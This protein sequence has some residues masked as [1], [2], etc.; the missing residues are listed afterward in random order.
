MKNKYLIF[1]LVLA[2]IAII[3]SCKEDF[4][5]VKPAGAL[6]QNILADDAGIEAMIIGAYAVLDGQGGPGGWGSATTNWVYG[7][8]RGMESNKGTDAGDQPDI[9]PIQRFNETATNG[10]LN[11]KWR[12]VYDAI[13]RCNSTIIITNLALT[14]GAITQEQADQ[15]IQQARALRGWYHFDAWRMWGGKVPYV[16]ETTDAYTVSN[17]GDVRPQI[18][19]DLSEG[20]KL[21]VNMGAIGKFNKT[22]C[23][24][25]L[26][27]AQMDMNKDYTTALALLNDAR[28]NGKKPN[29]ADIGLAATY[30]EI[31][32]IVNRNGIEA[33]YTVQ[34]SVND[35][36]GG[37]NGGNGEVLNFPYKGGGS[38]G[39]CCGFF[40]P[41]QE[42]VNSF[43]TTAAGLPLLDAYL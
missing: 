37:T 15:W 41:T 14:N 40:N 31:F 26:A 6:D 24:I 23:Q 32:D 20:I 16:D 1:F 35:G 36:S 9:N 42:F 29:G 43:R 28:T 7:S 4:L 2:G 5:T 11:V 10:Y 21:P 34:Y 17:S 8:I 13:A 3:G 39:G 30:G 27:K 22:V 12:T 25:L 18:I 38:P 33:I 19:A